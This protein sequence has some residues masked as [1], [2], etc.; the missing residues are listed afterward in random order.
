MSSYCHI[1]IAISREF[2][3][4]GFYFDRENNGYEVQDTLDFQ[5]PHNWITAQET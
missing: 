3:P 1:A 4:E 2:V 5:A